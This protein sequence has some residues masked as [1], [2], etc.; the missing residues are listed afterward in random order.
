MTEKSR[1]MLGLIDL[2]EALDL[3]NSVEDGRRG[4]IWNY[5]HVLGNLME[6]MTKAE[7]KEARRILEKWRVLRSK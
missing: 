5:Y 1:C 3:H 4:N 7:E 6:H 2:I